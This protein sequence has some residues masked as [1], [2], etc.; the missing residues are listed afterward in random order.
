M[1]AG[2]LPPWR[3]PLTAQVAEA[4]GDS[5]GASSY[6]VANAAIREVGAWLKQKAAEYDRIGD[7]A[8]D[9][10]WKMQASSLTTVAN[11]LLSVKI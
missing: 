3:H 4:I 11:E 5:D 2:N 7:E 1:G 9:P 8:S 6:F 10:V